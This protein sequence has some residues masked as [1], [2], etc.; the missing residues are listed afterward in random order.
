M[1]LCHFC[2]HVPV[3][4]IPMPDP[5]GFSFK[6]A[7]INPPAVCP[8]DALYLAMFIHG[9]LG[10]CF[11]W[12]VTGDGFRMVAMSTPEGISQVSVYARNDY[13]GQLER[14]PDWADAAGVVAAMFVI[15][16]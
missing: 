3:I 6:D 7:E 15:D 10:T 8:C 9:A 12:H 13:V 16:S 11:S 1:I 4:P 2:G 14:M 5:K